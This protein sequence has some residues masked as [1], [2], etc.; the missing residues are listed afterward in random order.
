M[1]FPKKQNIFLKKDILAWQRKKMNDDQPSL[2]Y[3]IK[4]ELIITSERNG[5]EQQNGKLSEYGNITKEFK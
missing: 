4:E 5:N 3:F 2:F 1:L